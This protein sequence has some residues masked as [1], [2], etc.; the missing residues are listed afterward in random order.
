MQNAM[1]FSDT[2]LSRRLESAEGHA[3]AQY[4][5]ARRRIFPESGAECM[6]YAGADVVFDGVESPVTQTF[7]LGL[8]QELTAGSLTVIERFFLDRGAPVVH[9][10]SPFAGA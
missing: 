6:R 7:G 5:L 3:C 1:L 4:A 2:A 10:V 8:L 9:E